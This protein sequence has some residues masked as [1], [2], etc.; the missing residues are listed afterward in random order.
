MNCESKTGIRTSKV[1][2]GKIPLQ[3]AGACKTEANICEGAK[4]AGGEGRLRYLHGSGIHC[5]GLQAAI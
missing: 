1:V 5:M 4:Q 3:M 2:L